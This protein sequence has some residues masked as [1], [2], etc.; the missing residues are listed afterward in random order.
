[1]DRQRHTERER[2]TL[3]Q[4]ERELERE[5]QREEKRERKKER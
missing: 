2:N 3:T 1:M 5:T 4:N